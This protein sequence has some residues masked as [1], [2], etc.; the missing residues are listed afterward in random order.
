VRVGQQE[1]LRNNKAAEEDGD[2]A[3]Q[4]EGS[5]PSSIYQDQSDDSEQNEDHV[6]AC[7]TMVMRDKIR[8]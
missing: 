2:T 6:N 3:P 8:R 7:N 1:G 4:H 5:T